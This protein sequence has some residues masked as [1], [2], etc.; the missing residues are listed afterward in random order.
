MVH[1]VSGPG[2]LKVFE[3]LREQGIPVDRLKDPS[4]VWVAEDHFV[5]SADKISAENIVKLSNFTR[6]YG[7]EKHFRAGQGIVHVIGPQMGITLPG[8]TIVC[9]DSHT[10]THGAFGALALGIGTSEVEHVLAS[11]TLWLERP[12]PFEVVVTGKRGPTITA[13]DVILSIIRNIGTAGGTGT[14]IEYRG[15][16]ISDMSME[17]RMTV[18]NMSIEAGARAGLIAPDEK[19][20]RYLRG[21]RYTPED[22]EEMVDAW[23]RDLTTDSGATFAKSYTIHTDEIAPQVSWGTNPAMTCDVTQSVPIPVDRVFIGSCTNARLEDLIDAARAARGRRVAPGVDAMVVPGSQDVKRQAEEMGLDRVFRDA[24]FEWRESGCS[25]C[26]GMNPD[27]LEPGQRCASTSNRNFEG[28]QGAGGRTHL[29]SPVMA[30]AA[31]VS[32]HFVDVRE[33]DLN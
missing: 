17:Q 28:R 8:T 16:G 26:L 14:V 15:S 33:M 22:Y 5:P 4:K 23:R 6:E 9:G 2:V 3:R 20:F 12:E 32:G 29:V 10:S 27:I 21:R 25:M 24:G 13:K 7:I 19:T 18:C 1:D 31:A 11:Q 30:A